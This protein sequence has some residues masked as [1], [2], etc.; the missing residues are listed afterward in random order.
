MLEDVAS[1]ADILWA[2]VSLLHGW[3]QLIDPIWAEQILGPAHFRFALHVLF[4]PVR[5]SCAC[6]LHLSSRLMSDLLSWQVSDKCTESLLAYSG[7]V[8]LIY[9]NSPPL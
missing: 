3:Y 2:A 6:T 8:I 7:L 4:R 5:I 9:Y 1:A